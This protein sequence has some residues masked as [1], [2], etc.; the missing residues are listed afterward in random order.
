MKDS[1]HARMVLGGLFVLAVMTIGI[2][3]LRRAEA[4]TQACREACFPFIHR[5]VDGNCYCHTPEGDLKQPK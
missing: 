3:Q 4:E 5:Q 1:P 2:V